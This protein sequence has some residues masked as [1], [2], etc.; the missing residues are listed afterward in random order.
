MI[1]KAILMGRL[2][3]DPELRHTNSGTAVC[4]FS[5]AINNGFGENAQTDFINCVAWNKTAEFVSKYFSKGKMIIVIGRISTRSWDGPDGKKNY[6]TEVVANEV[7]FGESK[8]D[9]GDYNSSPSFG[10]S[11]APESVPAM[12][13]MDD[14]GFS[15]LDT[16]DDLPF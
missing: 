14:G 8:R 3:R 2:T 4:S 12:P 9:G 13:A 11:S 16:D 1:N 10:G 7:S 5:L 15:P 6:A